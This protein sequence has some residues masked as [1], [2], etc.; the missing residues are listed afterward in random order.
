MLLYGA[1]G[2]AK[3]VID[4]LEASS[5]PIDGVFDDDIGRKKIL[6]YDVLGS[7]NINFLA[8]EECI[9]AIGNNC[10]RRKLLE[11]IRHQFGKVMH[12][13][14]DI[15]RSV[16]IGE[17]SVVFHHAILQSCVKIGDHVI[18]NTKASI[19]HDCVI[20]NFAHIAPN[21]TLCGGVTVG[22]GALI[23][24]GAVVIPNIKIGKW[25]TVGAGAV[26]VKDVPDY[27]VVVGSPATIKKY[28][29]QC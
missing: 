18:V 11:R 23:G 20:G 2:H 17:G 25:T 22:E 29:E 15:Q 14:S 28:N 21:A 1:S 12:P 24:A 27:A 4:C 26:V 10:I 5:I 6:E 8:N 16:T 9:I 3:V 7:Y 19:D 13:T